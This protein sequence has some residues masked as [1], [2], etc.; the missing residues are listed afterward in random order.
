[1]LTRAPRPH[2]R[3]PALCAAVLG[4]ATGSYDVMPPNPLVMSYIPTESA[5]RAFVDGM[6]EVQVKLGEIIM[7]QGVRR[8][9]VVAL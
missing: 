2:A 1:M 3:P 5:R 7:R 6:A 4:A 9:I 8:E